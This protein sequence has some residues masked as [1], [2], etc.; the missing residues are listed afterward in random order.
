MAGQKQSLGRWGEER[1]ADFLKEKGYEILDRNIR[2]EYGEIDLLARQGT[3]LVFVEVKARSTQAYGHPEES[4]SSLKQQ[5]MAD[6]AESYLQSHPV[7]DG[8][9][10]VDVIAVTRRQ[11]QAPEILH[12]EN[13]LAE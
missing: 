6:A 5:H 10:R 13:A 4:V 3:T 12:V 1:A 8:D 9:W 2:T 7:H 11:G